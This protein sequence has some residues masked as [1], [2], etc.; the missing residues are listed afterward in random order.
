MASSIPIGVPES[1]P[2]SSFAIPSNLKML[3]SN[4]NA[5][6][7]IKLDSSNYIVW[8]NQFYNILRFEI[9]NLR[10]EGIPEEDSGILS[11]TPMVM[12]EAIEEQCS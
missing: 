9:N 11:G 7:T 2:E 6:I 1:I 10:F 12:E 4:L 5:F 3:I 8:K